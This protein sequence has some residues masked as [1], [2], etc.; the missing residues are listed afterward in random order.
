M[1]ELPTDK[2]TGGDGVRGRIDSAGVMVTPSGKHMREADHFILTVSRD[3]FALGVEHQR[4]I[5]PLP[6]ET[7][8]KELQN[9]ASVVF[10]RDTACRWVWLII[11]Q[12]VE[13][14]AHRRM[15]GHG[16]QEVVEGAV[17]WRRSRRRV[18]RNR[19]RRW[20]GRL[21]ECSDHANACQ[22]KG[23]SGSNN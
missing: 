13:V 21:Q 7:D 20:I 22:S 4:S 10:V 19:R 1:V 15:E 3:R 11:A 12:H 16:L 23:W 5:R 18:R 14:A 9:F 17:R 2:G 8:R 6:I